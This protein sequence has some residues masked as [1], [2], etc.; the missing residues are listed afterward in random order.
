MLPII[1]NADEF[2]KFRYGEDYMTPNPNWS[3]GDNPHI[4]PQPEH[5]AKMIGH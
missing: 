2:L 1:E 3:N 4:I 5:P